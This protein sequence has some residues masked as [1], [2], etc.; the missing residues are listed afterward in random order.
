MDGFQASNSVGGSWEAVLAVGEAGTVRLPFLVAWRPDM[1]GDSSPGRWVA[2]PARGSGSGPDGG[3][4][5]WCWAGVGG[6]VESWGSPSA[7]FFALESGP[8]E[9]ALPHRG[10]G[11]HFGATQPEGPCEHGG[12]A[13]VEGR[14]AHTQL[15][16]SPGDRSE[17]GGGC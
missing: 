4:R 12:G 15:M 5:C 6:P 16:G 13:S 11:I 2:R 3:S 10:A 1:H 17:W 14:L 8:S 7:P 9:G